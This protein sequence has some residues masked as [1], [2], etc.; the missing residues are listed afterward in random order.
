MLEDSEADSPA[1]AHPRDDAPMDL[2]FGRQNPLSRLISEHRM[3]RG[4]RVITSAL[5][6]LDVTGQ[7]PLRVTQAPIL[8]LPGGLVPEMPED[9]SE[10]DLRAAARR[11][12]AAAQFL[13]V[14]RA[15]VVT[16]FMPGEIELHGAL[17]PDHP[18]AGW[19]QWTAAEISRFI[20]KL[21]G[22]AERK[23]YA[24]YF[25]L[26][27]QLQDRGIPSQAV[28]TGLLIGESD[29][30]RLEHNA[31]LQNLLAGLLD[32]SLRLK[33]SLE[34][35]QLPLCAADTAAR[36]IA[37]VPELHDPT[38][39]SLWLYDRRTVPM[40]WTID[41]WCALLDCPSPWQ[42]RA[43]SLLGALGSR[44][45]SGSETWLGGARHRGYDN[46]LEV[47]LAERIGLA[48][49]ALPEVL[50][51]TA[52]WWAKSQ[53]GAAAETKP[54]TTVPPPR[55]ARARGGEAEQALPRR[56]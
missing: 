56:F 4:H 42:G 43:K 32:G 15:V 38:Q 10:G 23:R 6:S 9:C 35:Q 50:Q 22:A 36:F 44:E 19:R 3:A 30:G 13:G 49:P 26:V 24:G 31:P 45:Q 12:A 1:T 48:W 46:R 18:L 2:I 25:A 5:P 21:P 8:W 16:D 40:R 34:T 14:H 7:Q 41:A 28:H 33:S 39:G 55:E 37:Q 52:R 27:Q 51:K 53:R 29:D 54:E 47:A 17:M 11:V 20:G